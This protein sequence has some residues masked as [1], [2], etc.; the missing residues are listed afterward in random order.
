MRSDSPVTN[1][2]NIAIAGSRERL[3][4]VV[5]AVGRRPADIER[6]RWESTAVLVIFTVLYSVVGYWLVVQMHVVGLETLDRFD[7]GL[8]VFH[9]EPAKLASIGFDYPPLSVLL[10]TPLTLFPTLVR[11]LV[12]VPLASAFFAGLTLMI[13]NTMLRRAQIGLS[14]RAAVLV[15]LG[16]NPL[17]IMYAAI[18]ARSF[19]WLAFVVAALGALF[20]WYVTADIR[21]V[22]LAGLS[23]SV[24]ALAGYGSLV[25]FLVSLVMVGAILARL[26]ADGREVEGTTVGFAAPT[27]YVIVLWAALNLVLLGDPFDWITQSSDAPT[28]GLAELSSSEILRGTV[29]LVV[30]GAPIA[31]VVLPA[32]VFTGIARRNRFALWLAVL[33]AVSILAPGLAVVLRL[34]D[35]PLVMS[36]ALPVLLVAVIGA[37]W[38]ARSATSRGSVVAAV[39]SGA[40][41]LSIPW[42]FASMRDFQHQGLERAF[43]DAVSTGGAQEGARTVDGSVVGYDNELE[44]AT[45]IRT[46][47]TEQD[48]ILTDDASTYAVILLTG[49]P[50]TFFDRVD[51]SDEAW[52]RAAAA[53]AEQVSYLLLARDPA[54]DLLSELY[55]TAATGSDSSFPVVHANQ[56]YT[57]VGVPVGGTPGGRM[58]SPSDA[59]PA[60]DTASNTDT[61]TGSAP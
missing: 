45:Y 40:L 46:H 35:S 51:E 59:T 10:L 12:V 23:Y 32:L 36:N 16:L 4:G 30:Y 13:I 61:D 41:L 7:R 28:G 48:S 19:L 3:S 25:W 47:V 57:L 56:R 29:D 15:A 14:L 8:M 42:T 5:Q 9:N 58:P 31:I 33:L 18:G 20:A 24:A 54:D 6:R 52:R 1:T 2:A 27:I 49:S 55:P 17:V 38:L 11:S 44:M 21:F 50:S 26:G 43:H 60:P 39:L 53:P 37:V 34:T 22:M